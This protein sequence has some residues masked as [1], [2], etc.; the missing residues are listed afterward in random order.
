LTVPVGP[1]DS[2]RSQ[3]TEIAR[4]WSPPGAPP[5]WGLTAA[6]FTRLAR[7]DDLLALAAEIPAA[8]MP[9]LLFCAA[10][11]HLVGE[12]RPPGLVEYFPTPGESQP[13]LDGRFGPAFAA[14]CLDHRAELRDL[15][16]RRRYQMN[17]VA[18]STQVAVALGALVRRTDS[19]EVALIDLG[20]GAGLGLHP[21]RY[22]HQLSDGTSFGDPTS[23]LTLRCVVEGPSP[24]LSPRGPS[25]SLPGIGLRVGIDLDPIDLDDPEDRRWARSCVPPEAG[26]LARFELASQ[27]ALSHRC[28]VVRGD[29]LE[30]LPAMLDDLPGHLLPVVVDSYTAV[31]FSADERARLRSILG[32]R[33][34]DGR[35]AWISLDPLVPLGT[36]GR[37]SVQGLE[38]PSRLVLDYQRQGV[39]ALLGLMTFDHG[40]ETGA[41]LARAHPSGTSLSWLEEPGQ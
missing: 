1:A 33:G 16:D 27:V 15:F 29:A 38:V 25:P 3:A 35:L 8:R 39:F 7:D 2:V 5:S 30:T 20:A 31:F 9:A 11:C 28:T 40:D 4:G 34:A 19:A 32:H 21:D 13:P 23:A 12:H 10:A 17:E 14:F 41:L 18:R 22:F 26:S 6:V 37:D 24:W 36:A